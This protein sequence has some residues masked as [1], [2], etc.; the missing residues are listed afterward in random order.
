MRGLL[1]G[2]ALG[3]VLLTTGCSGDNT[4]QQASPTTAATTTLPAAG[5]P[6]FLAEVAKSGLGNKDLANPTT[7]NAVVGLGNVTCE[8]VGDFG[9]GKAVQ[10]I[11]ESNANPTPEEASAFV[12]SAVNNLCPQY[13][14]LL[15]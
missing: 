7:R 9:Y 13:K 10:G 15:P 5:A 14:D 1:G 8:G 3:A 12:K 11:L 2:M 6:R 4:G